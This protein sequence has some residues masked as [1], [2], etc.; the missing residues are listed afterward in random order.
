MI[1]CKS[2]VEELE[3]YKKQALS[4]ALLLAQENKAPAR[5]TVLTKWSETLIFET[6]SP[7]IPIADAIEWIPRKE[8]ARRHLRPVKV[9][10]R[11]LMQA[12]K[13]AI[14]FTDPKHIAQ[15]FD[16][17]HNILR[18]QKGLD[19]KERLFELSKLLVVKIYEER[20]ERM[21]ERNRFTIDFLNEAKRTMRIDEAKMVNMIFDEVKS[22]MPSGYYHFNAEDK[23]ELPPHVIR[24][25][26]ELLEPYSF[27]E[28]GEDVLGVAFEIFLR[29]SM[30]GKELGAV[31]YTHLTLPT[32]ERV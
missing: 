31:S 11:E 19:A 27:L 2:M 7:Q 21:K 32:T 16:K 8:R 26:V 23:I 29:E 10:E 20:R 18:T 12:A 22:Q 24:E 15:L 25:I 1:E 30:T 5:Y 13:I 9:L 17:C 6:L 3:P 4:Y 14:T 28:T